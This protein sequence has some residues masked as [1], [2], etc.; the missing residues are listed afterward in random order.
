[1]RQ[2]TLGRTGI[3]IAQ[4]GFG[5]L[6][7]QRLSEEAT[8][9]IL[10]RAFE[11]GI[12]FYDTARG[13]KD[14]EKRIGIAFGDGHV[15]REKL[16]LS[17]KTMA[18][19]PEAFWK[20]LNKSLEMLRTDYID[21]YQIHCPGEL[22]RPGDGTGI[23]ECMLEAKEQGKIRHIGM[24]AQKCETA[25]EAAKSGLY[26]IVKY[27][28][29]YIS[30]EEELKLVEICKE[31]NVGFIAL[32]SLAGGLINNAKAA[33]AFMSQ[34]DHVVPIWGIQRERELDDWLGYMD[35]TVEMTEELKEQME[36]E[37]KILA[38]NFCCGCGHCMPC[39]MKIEISTCA[40][41]FVILRRTD[42]KIHLNAVNLEKMKAAETCINCKRCIKQCQNSLDIPA[43][44]EYSVADFRKVYKRVLGVDPK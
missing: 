24:T 41:M 27:P 42:P 21:V 33:M 35:K 28:F 40:R 12:Q 10:R 31:N 9:A 37:K 38:G 8:V 11:G 15:D 36:R 43:V 4:N 44:L 22:Y 26:D 13:Y 29:S 2:I 32:K 20:D 18:K 16:Y 17:T 34:Y 19:T 25:V 7:I 30:S 6:P 5:S 14:S 39:P 1:M 23:Y 3:T